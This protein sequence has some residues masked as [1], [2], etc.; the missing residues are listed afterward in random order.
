[1]L[2]SRET[3]TAPTHERTYSAPARFIECFDK[4]DY[5]IWAEHM[6]DL[7]EERKLKQYL[8]VETNITNYRAEEDHRA[9]A[10]I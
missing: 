4:Q 6:K 3:D 8:D 5:L 7:L 2:T 9:L 1:M 10:E